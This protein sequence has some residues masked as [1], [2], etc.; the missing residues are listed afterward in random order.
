MIPKKPAPGPPIRG[1]YRFSEK[2]MLKQQ[3]E[4]P[5]QPKVISL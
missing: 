4:M 5:I 1:G 3:S 2:M